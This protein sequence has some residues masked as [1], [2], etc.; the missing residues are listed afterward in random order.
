MDQVAKQIGDI[1][2]VEV[3]DGRGEVQVGDVVEVRVVSKSKGCP[4]DQEQP[5]YRQ[6]LMRVFWVKMGVL[7]VQ[8]EPA[9]IRNDGDK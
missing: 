4:R 8:Q 1:N 5:Q 9:D 6:A 7:A 2:N 3:L